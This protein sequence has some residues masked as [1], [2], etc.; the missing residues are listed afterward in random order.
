MHYLQITHYFYKLYIISK[1]FQLA[2]NSKTNVA[3][4]KYKVPIEV[5]TV[6]H[7]YKVPKVNWTWTKFP[8]S[9][10]FQWH[11]ICY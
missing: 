11:V 10:L 4:Q 3:I 8:E 5:V 1:H 9:R 7:N 2:R 6:T